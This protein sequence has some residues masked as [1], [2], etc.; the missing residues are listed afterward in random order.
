ME[1]R[2]TATA[3]SREFCLVSEDGRREDAGL[4]DPILA[5]AEAEAAAIKATRDL[6]IAAGEDPEL[7]MQF[8]PL[9]GE[10]I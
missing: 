3:G 5:N 7:M 6:L 10:V 8:Y 4:H 9:P 1:A 2:R